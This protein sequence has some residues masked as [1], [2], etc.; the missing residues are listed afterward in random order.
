MVCCIAAQMVQGV[1]GLRSHSMDR[2]NLVHHPVAGR[3]GHTLFS[4]DD[5]LKFVISAGPM[6]TLAPY[7][8]AKSKFV[9]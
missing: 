7:D 5:P 6:D 4:A 2:R 1:H 8:I 3:R 9:I